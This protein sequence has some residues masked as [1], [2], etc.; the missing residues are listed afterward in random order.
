MLPRV[1]LHDF[2]MLH[3]EG[4]DFDPDRIDE[5]F[6][7]AFARIW[8]GEV[9]NDGFNRLVL[10]AGIG[11]REIVILRAYCKYLRQAGVTFSEAYMQDALAAN[12]GIAAMLVELFHVRLDPDRQREAPDAKD[13][14]MEQLDAELEVMT[15]I[16]AALDE[17]ANLDEDRILRS[18]IGVIRAT[19]RTNYYQHGAGGAPKQYVSFK[20]DPHKI[21]ELPEPRPKY[22]ISV[23]SPRVEGVHLRGGAVARGGIRWSDRREDFR[24]EVLGLA[25]AQQVKNAVIVPVGSKGGFVPKKLPVD[26]DREAVRKEGIACY[27]IFIRGLLDVTDNLAGG[28]VVVPSRVVRHDGDDPYLV[29]AAD[30]GTATFSRHRQCA[31]PG[32]RLLARRCVRLRRLPGLRPQGDGDHRTRGVGVG[33]T[34]LPGAR[35]RLPEHRLHGRRDRRH[36][37]RRVRKRDAVVP[38][39][40]ARGRVQPPARPH[41]PEP[42]PGVDVRGA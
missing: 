26:A 11:W 38:A 36:G 5:T 25:K 30:K 21:P 40:P 10:R 35:D 23:Y 34:P 9:E 8:S 42:G 4:P 2:G 28:E 17:V 6:R 32:V 16:E 1:W 41:R 39:H 20:L 27:R 18:Y 29:V 15:R 22:E 12:P 14:A 31:G 37:G 7:E 24:T 3:G 33:Q 19:L 13:A